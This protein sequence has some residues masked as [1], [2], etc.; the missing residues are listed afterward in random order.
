MVNAFEL[1]QVIDKTKLRH[2]NFLQN[3]GSIV[4]LH[5]TM[6]RQCCGSVA[7]QNLHRRQSLLSQLTAEIAKPLHR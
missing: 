3:I 2:E 6:A 5:Q 4:S 1:K 7:M